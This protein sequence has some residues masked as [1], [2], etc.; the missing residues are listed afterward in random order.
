M[1]EVWFFGNCWDLPVF[2]FGLL[3][4]DFP[5]LLPDKLPNLKIKKKKTGLNNLIFN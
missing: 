3:P 4:N 2:K 5:T 1:L